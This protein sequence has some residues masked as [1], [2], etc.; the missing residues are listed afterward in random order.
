MMNGVTTPS[1]TAREPT[2]HR[3]RLA[4][5]LASVVAATVGSVLLAPI[6]PART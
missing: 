4:I 6:T 3:F 1:A 5:V 2:R